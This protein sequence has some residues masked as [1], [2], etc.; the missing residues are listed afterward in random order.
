VGCEV[1]I[2]GY[3]A[4]IIPLLIANNSGKMW[5]LILSKPLGI[6]SQSENFLSNTNNQI[7]SARELRDLLRNPSKDFIKD[8][9]GEKLS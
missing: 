6:M 9:Y 2:C 4:L 1:R 7:F 5:K 8:L 3:L